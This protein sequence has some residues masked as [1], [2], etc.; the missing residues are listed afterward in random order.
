MQKSLLHF[1]TFVLA[2]MLSSLGFA[3]TD[4]VR[5]ENVW[6]TDQQLNLEAGTPESSPAQPGWLSADWTLEPAG[7][8]IHVRLKNRWKGT[9]LHNQNGPL[10]AGPIESGWWSA[11]WQQEP[12]AE[13]IVRFKNRWKGTYL[14][15]ESGALSATEIQPGWLSAQWRIKG[16]AAATATS[17]GGTVATIGVAPDSAA[18]KTLLTNPGRQCVKAKF[19]IGYAATVRWYLPTDVVLDPTNKTLTLRDGATEAKKENIAVLETSCFEGNV[20]MFAQVSV[21][22]A[23]FVNEAIIIAAGTVVGVASGVGGAVVCAGTVGAGCIAIAA[24]GPAV[25]GTVTAVG[26]ALPEPK[27]TIYLGAPGKLELDG[28][29]WNATAKE[30]RAYEEGKPIGAACAADGECMN[31]TCARESAA[32]GNQSI[33]CASGKEGLYAGYEY[34]YGM[35]KG[36]VC[37]SD[38]MCAS[39]NCKGNASGLQRGACQ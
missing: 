36:T 22:G 32:D 29:V 26:L 21:I 8:G 4:F 6:K 15:T 31:N 27:T 23:K 14:N 30:V 13:G 16:S 25:G 28:T 39:G 12:V 5:L 19:G 11:Q 9:Y 38:A 33:C 37:W 24:I 34:C 35:S 10:E 18:G 7:D 17:A 20:K 2:A 1:I 3:Q